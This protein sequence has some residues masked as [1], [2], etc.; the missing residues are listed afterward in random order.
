MPASN[1]KQ[2]MNLIVFVISIT[3]LWALQRRGRRQKPPAQ[4]RR[5]QKTARAA[6]SSRPAQ[7][8]HATGQSRQLTARYRRAKRKIAPPCW[9]K[10]HSSSVQSVTESFSAKNFQYDATRNKKLLCMQRMRR[11]RAEMAG[12]VSGVRCLE[13]P[14]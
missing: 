3:R 4:H 2:P 7:R 5:K 9:Y 10:S 1:V 14:D 11:A 8:C 13:Y 12:A 6:A